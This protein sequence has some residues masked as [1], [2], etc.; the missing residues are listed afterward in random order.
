MPEVNG[1]EYGAPCWVDIGTPDVQAAG[2]FYSALLGWDIEYGPEEMGH[3]SMA[4]LGPSS[5]PS[6]PVSCAKLDTTGWRW[7]RSS[8]RLAASARMAPIARRIPARLPRNAWVNRSPTPG[9]SV[10]TSAGIP[11]SPYT[12]HSPSTPRSSRAPRSTNEIP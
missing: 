3:Y 2:A 11:L 1:H 9:S 10:P 5:T 7:G 6:S 4:R 12:L 8:T